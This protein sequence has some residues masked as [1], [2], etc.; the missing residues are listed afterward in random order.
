MNIIFTIYTLY[1]SLCV[2]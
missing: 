1:M 2:N